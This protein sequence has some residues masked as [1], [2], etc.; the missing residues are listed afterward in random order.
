M[1]ILVV[2]VVAPSAELY[3][4]IDELLV[5]SGEKLQLEAVSD[6]SLGGVNTT[7]LTVES[8]EENS[9]DAR[10]LSQQHVLVASEGIERKQLTLHVGLY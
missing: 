8:S 9:P 5:R 10:V 7:Q 3:K 6:T 4:Q 1:L 2:L